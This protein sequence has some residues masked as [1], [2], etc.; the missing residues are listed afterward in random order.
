MYKNLCRSSQNLIYVEKFEDISPL[1]HAADILIT[2]V[3]STMMEFAALDKPVVL[4]NNPDWASY[5]NYNPNDIEFKW[6][7]IGMEAN[8]LAE[9]KRAVKISL[10]K[11]DIKKEKRKQYT[12]R[13]FKNKYDGQAVERII[14]AALD[15]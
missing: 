1:L 8:D 3:S 4:F 9:L 15:L 12:D 13:L 11:P 6:R 10:L 5:E 7:D 14:H 2:D